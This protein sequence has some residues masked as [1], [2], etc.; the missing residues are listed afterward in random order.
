MTSALSTTVMLE[1][2]FEQPLPS[3]ASNIFAN[4]ESGTDMSHGTPP[5]KILSAKLNLFCLH[6]GHPR[7]LDSVGQ[8][9][10]AW[11]RME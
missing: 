2:H 8:Q 10:C 4:I 1:Q 7:P 9:R 6:L 11:L 5:R 3:V